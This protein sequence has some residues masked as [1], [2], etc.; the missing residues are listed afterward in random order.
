MEA[1]Q[2]VP[3]AAK[4]ADAGAAV[5]PN[6]EMRSPVQLWAATGYADSNRSY[7]PNTAD[8]AAPTAPTPGAISPPPARRSAVTLPHLTLSAP[9]NVQGCTKN[10]T[11]RH[12]KA[13]A[14]QAH[15]IDVTKLF[16]PIPGCPARPR[17]VLAV[18]IVLVA[19]HLRGNAVPADRVRRISMPLTSSDDSSART[20]RVVGTATIELGLLFYFL[21]GSMVAPLFRAP[22]IFV[23]LLVRDRFSVGVRR[24]RAGRAPF[25]WMEHFGQLAQY[26]CCQV[27]D[28]V[29]EGRVAG[30]GF[31]DRLHRPRQDPQEV[32]ELV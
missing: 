21:L 15:G 31:L 20:T 2:N 3:P 13:H 10:L 25:R 5:A 6:R 11:R 18:V 1:T 12:I 26:A 19:S 7:S 29:R 17:A 23:A 9:S 28:A 14:Q 24:I 27:R 4:E 22:V 30:L 8:N 16:C 32:M